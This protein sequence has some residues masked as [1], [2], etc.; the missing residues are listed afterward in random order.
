[1][2]RSMSAS[3]GSP[4]PARSGRALA[5]GLVGEFRFTS[6]CAE[7]T[8]ISSSWSC[9]RSVHLRLRG[10]DPVSRTDLKPGDGSPPPA[11]SGHLRGVGRE[12]AGRFTSAC[13][14]R[15]FPFRSRT[16]V[17]PV[18][19]RLRGADSSTTEM[20]TPTV[21]SPPPARSGRAAGPW[22][23]WCSWFTSACAERTSHH[24]GCAPLPPVH[25]RLRG[26]DGT[27]RLAV[28]RGRGSPPPARSGRS[29]RP[30]RHPARWFTSACAERT[31]TSTAAPGRSPVHLRLRGAD[32]AVN[33]PAPAPGGS[34]PPARS[35]RR[36]EEDARRDRRFTSACAERTNPAAS[37]LSGHAVHLRLRGADSSSTTPA[38]TAS[39]S[40]PP[41]RSGRGPGDPV[42]ARLRFTSACAER[43]LEERMRMVRS[44]V[45]LRLRG[46]DT[47]R[48]MTPSA[49]AGSPPPARSGP[50]RS[51]DGVR[52]RRFTSACAERT[53]R[54]RPC[55]SGRP[56]HLRLR[57]ADHV[58]AAG[59]PALSGSPPPARSGRLAER[60]RELGV[61]FT[62]ACAERTCCCRSDGVSA[63][64]H[65][66]L[67][68]ADEIED[69]YGTEFGGSPPPARSGPCPATAAVGMKWFTSACAER[70][71]GPG[72]GRAPW[73]VHLR[74]RGAD[75]SRPAT[76]VEV[77]HSFTEGPAKQRSLLP[78]SRSVPVRQS[79]LAVRLPSARQP[80]GR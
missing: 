15:T 29:A 32:Q 67:R 66:R 75:A 7:R 17:D 77:G 21:G 34:P 47:P 79:A 68:G 42:R 72:A 38:P 58:P 50:A 4:P 5:L 51:A 56:V 14:E 22:C 8:P 19:L 1:M 9:W 6:A 35:G 70:T 76:L 57:G 31:P 48:G 25:L 46:A 12:H 78:W 44:P 73:S 43:T 60:A 59:A 26:A 52:P 20:H 10:A 80:Y 18:H 40:P 55:R 3:F 27:E 53:G 64:V 39:G 23:G 24:R 37:R 13:A 28:L 63:A 69:V 49:R 33:T 41:A 61:R 2:C 62:S 54:R 71:A 11:R 45:H 16:T 65:L 30:G 74:L 36:H